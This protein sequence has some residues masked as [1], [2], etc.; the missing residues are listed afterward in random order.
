MKG[1]RFRSGTARTRPQTCDVHDY[2]D[3][4]RAALDQWAAHLESLA[5]TPPPAALTSQPKAKRAKSQT[6]ARRQLAR[7]MA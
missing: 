1:T 3:E 6:P 2:L 4:K 7:P 5:S